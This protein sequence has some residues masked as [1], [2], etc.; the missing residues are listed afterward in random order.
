[1][2]SR[3]KRRLDHRTR[4]PT[5]RQRGLVLIVALTVV[6]MMAISAGALIRSVETTLA[7]SGNLGSMNAARVAADA[8]IEQAVADLFETHR[9]A[10]ATVDDAAHGY[11]AA[12]L[13]GDSARGV[14][15]I[16]QALANYPV[17]RPVLDLG[18]GA[19]VRYVIERACA[20]TGPP[21]IVDC[22][23]APA[24]IVPV[25]PDASAEPP[26]VPVYRVTARVD[27]PGAATAFAQAW[28]ADVPTGRRLSWRALAD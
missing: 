13:G 4:R 3:V 27:G 12:R 8:A 22:Q 25:A 26:W 6:L 11:A 18:D 5:D 1:V 19:V 16:L 14:P 20:S 28:L 24:G 15:V 7:V 2:E 9:I 21:G 17:G 10:D 23:L